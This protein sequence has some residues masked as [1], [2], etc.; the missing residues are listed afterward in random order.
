MRIQQVIYVKSARV[1]GVQ[2][3]TTYNLNLNVL[4]L[5]QSACMAM[6]QH[7]TAKTVTVAVQAVLIVPLNVLHVLLGLTYSIINVM[8][9]VL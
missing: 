1:F 6:T 4:Y 3:L 2:I 7:S 8:W 9:I 5:A